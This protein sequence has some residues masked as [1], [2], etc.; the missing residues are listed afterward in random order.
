MNP[1][2]AVKTALLPVSILSGPSAPALL[3]ALGAIHSRPRIGLLTV[4]ASDGESQRQQLPN[5]VI[6]RLS[7]SPGGPAQDPAQLRRQI[8]TIAE[9]G[10]VEHLLIECDPATP[11]IAFASLFL[12][13]GRASE[14]LADI[15]QL[16]SAVVALNSADL[17]ASLVHRRETMFSPCFIAEQT[18][19]ASHIVLESGQDEDR[20]GLARA[21]VSALNPAAEVSKLSPAMAWDFLPP[22]GCFDFAAALD[23]AGWRKLVDGEEMP[24]RNDNDRVTTLAYRAWKPFH[25]ARFW[26][27][28]QGGTTG[29]FRAK[30]FFWLATRMDIVGGL[31]LAGSECHVAAAGEWWAAR[32]KDVRESDMPERTR[33]EWREPFG[34]RRQA[35]A[36]MGIA[37]DPDAVRAQLDACLLTDS[38]AAAGA[39]SWQSFGDP[40]PSWSHHDHGHDHHHECGDSDCCHH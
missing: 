39:E 13:D 3:Q 16:T 4:E 29:I 6:E 31:N 40:F 35:V 10:A 34:D 12:P 9:S 30:G 21:M 37:F 19:F 18:E 24:D 27:F 26:N 38:E 5:F 15:A 1:P 33:K 28:L 17:L 32:E 36:V 22:G 20:F 8:R 14:S 7:S 25:P 2:P 23:G 11:A